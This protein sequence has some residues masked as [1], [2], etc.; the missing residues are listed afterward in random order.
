M[1]ASVKFEVIDRLVLVIFISVRL[2]ILN[3]YGSV[4][5]PAYVTKLNGSMSNK[6]SEFFVS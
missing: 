2:D 3:F 5:K 6:R 4:C 1:L